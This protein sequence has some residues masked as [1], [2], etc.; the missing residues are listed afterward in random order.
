MGSLA[1]ANPAPRTFTD[2]FGNR[3]IF[4]G[5]VERV[6]SLAPNVTESVFAMGAGNR[7]VGVTN[8]CNYPPEAKA[9]TRVGGIID[10]DFEKIVALKPDLVLAVGSSGN[11]KKRVEDL[12]KLLGDKIYVF[13]VNHLDDVYQLLGVLGEIFGL[14][15]NAAATIQSMQLQIQLVQRKARKKP[16]RRVAF[17]VGCKPDIAVAQDSFLQEWIDLAG[18]SNVIQSSSAYPMINLEKLLQLR[19]ETILLSVDPRANSC[20]TLIESLNQLLETRL[21][22]L[23][24]DLFQRPG[25]RAA[26]A[27]TKLYQILHPPALTKPKRG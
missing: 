4:S 17:V 25:P 11:S 23:D 3:V 20:T 12:K 2:T 5:P 19:P 6:V 21:Q 13:D 1:G 9:L 7:L 24:A 8:Y 14:Q 27:I 16:T 26:E 18:G 10:F 15:K 22:Q